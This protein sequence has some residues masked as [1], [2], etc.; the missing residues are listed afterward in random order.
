MVMGWWV[1]VAAG[2]VAGAAMLPAMR[3]DSTAP[4]GGASAAPALAAATSSAPPL[5]WGLYADSGVRA[6]AQVADFR[7]ATGAPISRVLEFAGGAT[8]R[9]IS[10]P[11]WVFN[12]HARQGYTL[13][14]SVPML[15]REQP[16]TL[17]RCAAGAYNGYWR[18][19]AQRAVKAGAADTSMRPGWEFNGDWYPWSALGPGQAEA[20]A[21]CFRQ[22]V[23]TMRSVAG[24]RFTFVWN[25]NVSDQKM[26]AELAYP[27]D[28]Y[29]DY[30]AVDIYDYSW[31]NY[32]NNNPSDAARRA[33][34]DR[35]LNGSRGLRFW[36]DFA[37]THAKPLG[38]SEWGLAWRADGHGGG[39]NVVFL[40]GMMSF[41]TDPLNR[42]AYATYFNNPN[43]GDLRHRISGPGQGFAQAAARFR[44]WVTRAA[45]ASTTI[46]SRNGR[47]TTISRKFFSR[48]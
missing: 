40:D 4:A 41:I 21:G 28:A 42:V 32:R 47:S 1:K 39:D 38:I 18:S 3:V 6:R 35:R 29:V 23:T 46:L 22:V 48:R 12:A 37:R 14:L 16:A 19:I 9:D 30:V 26:P 7:R 44:F 45:G 8:W 25:P 20:Y 2:V 36:A 24:Q 17:A 15:P 34:W 27:G 13:E 31:I 43:R 5:A 33:E 11:D 10:R